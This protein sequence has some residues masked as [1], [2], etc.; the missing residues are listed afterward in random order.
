MGTA[1]SRP[2]QPPSIVLPKCPTPF[3]SVNALT[4]VMPCPSEKGYERR[5]TPQGL[6][7]VY[8]PDPTYSVQLNT[9][10]SVVFDGTT[11]NDLQTKNVQAYGT[12]LKERDRFVGE[13]A[14]LDGQISR[15]KK[16]QDAFRR[17]QDA[18][19]VRDRAPDAYQ[20]AR[21]AYYTLLKGEKWIEEEKERL[22]KAEVEPLAKRF[23]EQ[24]DSTLR[25]F[26]TQRRTIDVVNGLKDRV[27]S[28]KDAMKYSADTFKDQLEKVQSAIN[29]ERRGRE[30]VTVVRAWDWVDTL[31]NIA[32]VVSLLY[33]GWMIVKKIWFRRPVVTQTTIIQ[34]PRVAVL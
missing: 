17:L 34:P 4:C 5:S 8:K 6:R 29:M 31:L 24:R 2:G 32:I 12:F 30:E 19:N 11:L 22:L 33:V 16:I 25:Q 9:L 23:R 15:T 18:E 3:E 21:S 26:E 28:L 1:S 13:L 10:S 27:L 7:C 14:I 20:R